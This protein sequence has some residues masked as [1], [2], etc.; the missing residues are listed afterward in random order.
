[1]TVE[2]LVNISKV[3]KNKK[4][5][6]DNVSLDVNKNEILTLIGPNGAGKTTLLKIMALID[7]PTDGEIYFRE[8]LVTQKNIEKLRL[9]VTMVFQKPI[10]FN[11]SVYKNIAYGLKLRGLPK[12]EIERM[13]K[14]ALETVGLDGFEKR[15]I[16]SLSGGEQQRVA[17]A[18][19]IILS[20]E[21]LLLDEPLANIDPVNAMILEK[22]VSDLRK[23][24]TI[25]MSTHDLAHATRL[26]DK[27]AFINQGK[28][29]QRG[30]AMDILDKPIDVLTARFIGYENI[31]EGTTR[32]TE[33]GYTTISLGSVSIEAISSKQGKCHV[34]IRP[35]DITLFKERTVT[36]ARNVLLGTIV[37][38][39]ELKPFVYLK[40]DV[41]GIPFNV[42]I[43]RRSFSELSL[44]V[45][46]KVFLSFKASAVKVF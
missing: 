14:E 36:S 18:R 6:L 19:A 24:L 43:T 29:I 20:P 13:V 11:T 26:A 4:K 9:N 35:E 40:V 7:T 5:A 31:F 27:I 33:E 38:A 46:D 22:V 21:L 12:R 3:Y 32:A 34:A 28:V 1:M 2:R 30:D 10:F 8:Q 25:V 41:E 42:K 16:R 44:R 17:L 23:E 37:E 15:H 45:G 39:R